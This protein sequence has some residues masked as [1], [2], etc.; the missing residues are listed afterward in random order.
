[1]L[2]FVAIDK[3]E[4]YSS[5]CFIYSLNK[6]IYFNN[7]G[8]SN[9]TDEGKQDVDNKSG[10]GPENVF[11]KDGGPLP[12]NGTYYICFSQYSFKSNASLSNPIVATVI[13][14][15]SSNTVLTYTKNFTSYY[16]DY[17]DCDTSSTGFLYSVSYP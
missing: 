9:A 16:R 15:Y 14:T 8:P 3:D 5:N 4:E 7:P 1:V 13:V 12:P 2:S 6:I 10:K 17:T 11:W